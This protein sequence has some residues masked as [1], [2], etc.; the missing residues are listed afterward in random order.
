MFIDKKAYP[1]NRWAV[2]TYY[3]TLEEENSIEHR[4]EQRGLHENACIFH[5]QYFVRHVL[6]SL[7]LC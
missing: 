3:Y 4:K 2:R 7:L 6:T 1:S 5:L